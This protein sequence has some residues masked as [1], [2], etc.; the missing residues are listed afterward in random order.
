MTVMEMLVVV[1]SN[2]MNA[3]LLQFQ[4][5]PTTRSGVVVALMLMKWCRSVDF[6]GTMMEFKSSNY[7]S[8]H[9]GDGWMRCCS[10]LSA[11]WF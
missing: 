9:G 5:W 7:F 11:R 2:V 1:A 6:S 10:V 4:W 3:S 8:M